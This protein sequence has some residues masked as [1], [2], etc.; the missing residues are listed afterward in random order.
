VNQSDSTVL[1]TLITLQLTEEK[2]KPTALNV[3]LS[4]KMLSAGKHSESSPAFVEA[5]KILTATIEKLNAVVEKVF[6]GNAVFVVVTVGEHHAIRTK[7]Q[8]D[9][10]V[11][12]KKFFE[13][14]WTFMF[15]F[16]F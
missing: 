2:E 10:D 13:R 12:F 1:R 6:G 16:S 3:R 14:L 5:T 11:S 7:R 4:L 8:A 15:F 9:G